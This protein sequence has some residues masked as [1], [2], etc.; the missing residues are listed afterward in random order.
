M[1][2]MRVSCIRNSCLEWSGTVFPMIVIFFVQN[3]LGITLRSDSCWETKV[4]NTDV[5]L[6]ESILDRG[7]SWHL[8]RF[9]GGI[10][11]ERYIFT[12]LRHGE[13]GKG[14]PLTRTSHSRNSYLVQF[15]EIFHEMY[16]IHRS[17][18]QNKLT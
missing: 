8:Y 13:S 1:S 14:T 11:F 18:Y 12:K 5:A 10:K 7:L 2:L 6:T 17:R 15:P 9:L 4:F 3:D 16:F